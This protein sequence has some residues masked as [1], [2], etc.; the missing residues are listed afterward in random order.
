MDA[1]AN[2]QGGSVAT[3]PLQRAEHFRAFIKEQAW[4]IAV[5]ANILASFLDLRDDAGAD[6]A[7]RCLIASVRASRDAMRDL[8]ALRWGVD[9]A[10]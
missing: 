2:T 3:L 9:H 5:R 8:M 7:L 10:E 1:E 4:A 6:Y